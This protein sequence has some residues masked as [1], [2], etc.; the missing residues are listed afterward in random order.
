MS[1]SLRRSYRPNLDGFR[2]EDRIVLNAASGAMVASVAAAGVDP[3][4]PVVKAGF[5]Q[6]TPLQLHAAFQNFLNSENRAAQS[7]VR[8]LAN[9]QSP[10]NLLASLKANTSIQ[11][12]ILEASVQQT[13]KRIPT[14]EQNLF[15]PTGGVIPGSNPPTAGLKTQIDAMLA[16]LLNNA[17][18]LE[19][20]L[21]QNAPVTILQ[22]YQSCK[23]A[24][25]QFVKN[26]I[27]SGVFR[28]G[29]NQGTG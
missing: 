25:M 12:G 24:M 26:A 4:T 3:P 11:G 29:P 27:A 23:A 14:G 22:T 9:G 16:T 18:T 7:T 1:T 5:L 6:Q 20:A 28:V 10:D 15:N 17:T 8:G 19:N 21:N 2:L 13:T